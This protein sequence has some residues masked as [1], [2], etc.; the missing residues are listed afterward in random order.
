MNEIICNITP[1]EYVK[2]T[3]TVLTFNVLHILTDDIRYVIA[4]LG[5]PPTGW[6]DLTL[7]I[8]QYFPSEFLKRLQ[9]DNI[10][11]IFDYTFEGFSE[12]QSPIIQILENNCQLYNIDPKKI[13]YCSGN[14]RDVSSKINAIPMYL[15]D[16]QAHFHGTHRVKV[17]TNCIHTA[18][19]HCNDKLTDKIFL[20][21]SRRNRSHRVMAHAMLFYSDIYKYGIISQ[22]IL[23]PIERTF[24][25]DTVDSMGLNHKLIKRF[26][27]SLPLIAD[28]NEFHKNVPFDPLFKLHASTLFSIVNETLI[29]DYNGTSLFY[30]EKI[31]KPIISFQPMIIYGQVGI[32]HN[33]IELGFKTYEDYFDLSFDFEADP[34][35]R[36]KKLLLSITD[37]VIRLSA[38]TREE[39][40]N[41]RFQHEKI[42]DYNYQVFLKGYHSNKQ[43]Q[44]F[45]NKVTDLFSID[46]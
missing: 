32:N 12:K 27:K 42:L 14:L 17:Q 16:N 31:L 8:F 40:I 6:R 21:L 19:W 25:D 43:R 1:N 24:S 11:L 2:C 34:I 20:S 36:Y 23:N 5:Y 26:S 46:K 37:L 39:K 15:L 9:N 28:K 7:D 41:W 38:M 22:D 30:S 44:V 3:Q 45:I 35:I 13:F 10:I 18:K 33:L 4:L 29:D